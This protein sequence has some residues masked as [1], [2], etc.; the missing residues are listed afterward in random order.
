MLFVPDI[1]P[2]LALKFLAYFAK[3]I[4]VSV[5]ESRKY[6]SYRARVTITGYP[7]RSE[8]K[9]WAKQ[10]AVRRFGF[11]P[12]IPI[13]LVVGGSSGARSINRALM[14]ALGELLP[15]MQIIHITGN[16]DWEEVSANREMLLASKSVDGLTHQRYQIFAYLH[17]D[18]GAALS[19]ADLVLARAGASALGEFPVFDLPAILVPYPYAWRYQKVNADYMAKRGAALVLR[20]Q[21]LPDQLAPLVRE[22]MGNPE[23]RAR[24]RKAMINLAVPDAAAS[25]ADRLVK[26]VELEGQRGK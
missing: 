20:D 9:T 3:E 7:I 25:I 22:L 17:E 13:L 23:K 11:D 12:E 5:D 6:F 16:L 18:M 26:L 24:M 8:L 14:G 4:A 2:G 21:D 15:E 19:A 1:E 10:D